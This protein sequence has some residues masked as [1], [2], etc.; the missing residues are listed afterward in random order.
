MLEAEREQLPLWIPAAL[1][2]GIAAW[3]ALPRAVEWA[4]LILASAGISLAALAMGRG[5]RAARAAAIAAGCVALGAALIWARAE[6]VAAPVLG[7]PMV[8]TFTA[9]VVDLDRLPARGA[10][11]LVLA[12]E[13]GEGGLPPRFRLSVDEEN[14]ADG[15]APG[16]RIRVRARLVP[17]PTAAVPGAYDFA[18]VAWFQRI[19]ATGRALDPVVLEAP[20]VADWRTRLASWRIGL[21]RHIQAALPDAEGGIAAALATGDTGAIPEDDNEAMRRAGLAHLLSVSGLH[22]TAVVGATMVMALRLLALWP[23]LALRAPLVL[24]AAAAGA[25][26]GIAYTLM[27]G[28]EVPTVR[29]CV[30]AL[31]V[32][33]GI[34]LGRD[35]MTLRLVAA[36]ALVVMLLWPEAVIGPSFQ[37]SF[38]AIIAIVALGDQPLVRARLAAREGEGRGRRIARALAGLLLTGLVVEAALAPIALYHFHRAGLYG[39]LANI[40]AIPLTTFVVM[41]LEAGALLLD[42]IGLGGPLW[43]LAGQG[44]RLLLGLAHLVAAMPG[45]SAMLPAMPGG[46]FALVVGGGLWLA[47]WRTRLRRWGLAPLILGMAWAAVAPVPALLVT[48]DGRH[49]AMRTADG[50][51]ALLRA[52]VGDYVQDMFGELA[53]T[54]ETALAFETLPGAL[55]NADLCAATIRRGGRNWRLLATRSAYPVAIGALVRACREADIVVS[56]RRLPR[57]CTPRWLK[58]DRPFL[59]RTGGLAI[60]LDRGL[61]RTVAERAGEHPWTA[62]NPENEMTAARLPARPS[63]HQ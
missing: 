55:C 29:S 37:L 18:P 42:A 2:A 41:P 62:T 47:L 21:S 5:G 36:G 51:V 63:A 13:R 8:A 11:R 10:V 1:G 17:P 54:D 20:A 44:L 39:A 16:A 61:V 9:R 32:L 35:A 27:T 4:A 28:A 7:R 26:A 30:A 49:M 24:I 50:R 15:V 52:R 38:A 12:P 33:L 56:D 6:R 58:A 22:L 45:A 48:G 46:A 23:G 14:M 25:L 53:G 19:G 59:A 3:F 43:W 60:D 34:A 57:T 40:V 31:L